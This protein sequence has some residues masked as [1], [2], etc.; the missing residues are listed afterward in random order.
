[1]PSKRRPS[2]RRRTPRPGFPAPPKAPTVEPESL[3]SAPV[4]GE[5][6]T[7]PT[8]AIIRR[9]APVQPTASEPSIARVSGRDYTYIKRD[10][11]RIAIIAGVLLVT[12]IVLSLFL[13]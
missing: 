1:L 6:A 9:S 7:A 11:Q 13:P 5:K 12:L 4:S 10:L 8:P 3:A 2:R